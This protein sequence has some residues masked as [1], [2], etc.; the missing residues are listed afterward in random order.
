MW[1][2]WS[3]QLDALTGGIRPTHDD[4]EDV[5]ASRVGPEAEFL[6]ALGGQSLTAPERRNCQ[7]SV[8]RLPIPAI[9]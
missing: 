4:R 3:Y 8:K 5:V 1:V 7:R 6:V 9:P 2:L